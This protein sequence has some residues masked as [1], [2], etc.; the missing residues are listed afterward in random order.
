MKIRQKVVPPYYRD[1]GRF[2]GASKGVALPEGAYFHG[3]DALVRQ[4]CE[5][6]GRDFSNWEVLPRV[7]L[8]G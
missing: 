4:V 3:N 5:A 2:W 7:I 1:V 8:L 6:Y